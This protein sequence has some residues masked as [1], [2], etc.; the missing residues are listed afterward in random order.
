MF[1]NMST[2][3]LDSNEAIEK[4]VKAGFKKSQAKSI[5]EVL[6]N[7]KIKNA[8]SPVKFAEFK[9]EL[10]E[11]FHSFRAEMFKMMLAQTAVIVAIIKI[12]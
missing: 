7:S 1:S 8:V 2:L 4:L 6:Q 11:D 5:I 10:K 9:S 3:Y 12:L